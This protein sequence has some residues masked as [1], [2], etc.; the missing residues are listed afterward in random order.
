MICSPTISKKHPSQVTFKRVLN[1]WINASMLAF[2]GLLV[3]GCFTRAYDLYAYLTFPGIMVGLIGNHNER[4][5]E[6]Y[7]ER[8][9]D[10]PFPNSNYSG[11]HP[12][13]LAKGLEE[14]AERQY[15]PKYATYLREAAR[16]IRALAAVAEKVTS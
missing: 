8:S 7:A 2:I 12:E 16:D 9:K 1:W 13:N 5:R 6:R 4:D 10:M 11:P 3:L 14:I 15:D